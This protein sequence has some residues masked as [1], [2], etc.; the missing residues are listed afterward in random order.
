LFL[1]AVLLCGRSA[2]AADY[3]LQT[4]ETAHTLFQSA[5]NSAMFAEAA[6]QY[7]FL[8]HE[9][10]IRNG[11]LFYTLGNSWFMAGNPGKAIL[12]YRRAEQYLPNNDDLKHNLNAA[13]E[14][15]TDLIPEK[16]AHPMAVKVLG[17]HLNTSTALRWRIFTVCWISLWAAWFWMSRTTRK[18][19]RITVAVAGVLSAVLL[20]SLVTEGILKYRTEQG[21]IIAGEVLARKGAG[22]M[23]TP[24]FLEPLHSGT[25][26]IMIEDRGNWLHIRLDDGQGCWIP[27][28]AAERVALR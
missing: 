27:A 14:L 17:W 13:L 1:A 6:K 20:T 16:E 2:A 22:Q 15:R 5:T 28:D 11:R 9:E 18:E 23:Y 8:V 10:G 7:E 19:A 24:A 21:V 26:F 4:L 25:E 3:Q 12:N